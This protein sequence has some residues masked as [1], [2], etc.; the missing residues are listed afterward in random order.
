[1]TEQKRVGLDGCRGGWFAAWIE[2]GSIEVARYD[3]IGAVWE[4]HHDAATIYVDVPIGLP[5]DGSRA[6]DE[7]ARSLLGLRGRSVFPTPPRAVVDAYRDGV[8]YDRAN[9]IARERTGNGL[10]RQTWNIVPKIAEVDEL[11]RDRPDASD[12][13]VESHPEL[14]FAALNDWFPIALSKRSDRG[15]RA[16][17]YVLEN[18]LEAPTGAYDRAVERTLRKHVAR[19][20]IVDAL[21]LLSATGHDRATVPGEPPTDREGLPMRIAHP[22]IDPPW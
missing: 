5:T 14:S 19:D 10:Q 8:G 11:L 17:L 13:I 4:R 18:H 20:D 16:R 9:E 7:T 6:C 21:A 12:R 3:D 1:M 2:A 15:R 22:A